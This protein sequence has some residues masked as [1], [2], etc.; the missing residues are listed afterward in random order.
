MDGDGDAVGSEDGGGNTYGGGRGRRRGGGAGSCGVRGVATGLYS[1]LE[2][3]WGA[4]FPW[5]LHHVREWVYSKVDYADQLT[6]STKYL[7]SQYYRT[8]FL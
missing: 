8:A 1:L 4:Q 2:C 5:Q 7:Y 6:G 3:F